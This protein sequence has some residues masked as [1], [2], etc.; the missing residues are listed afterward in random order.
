LELIESTSI[1]TAK[2]FGNCNEY[3][4]I[5]E[6]ATLSAVDVEVGGTAIRLRVWQCFTITRLFLDFLRRPFEA[7]HTARGD[8]EKLKNNNSIT[9]DTA[10]LGVGRVKLTQFTAYRP[11]SVLKPPG[12]IYHALYTGPCIR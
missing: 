9:L 1:R 7:E 5:T 12:A 3:S 8:A 11:V 6:C 10:F 4:A 2:L